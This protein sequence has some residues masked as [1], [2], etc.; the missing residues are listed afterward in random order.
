M[1]KDIN[2]ITSDEHMS[3]FND[4]Y[5]LSIYN[6]SSFEY[7]VI[8]TNKLLH[9]MLAYDKREQFNFYLIEQLFDTI[10][11]IKNNL[12]KISQDISKNKLISLLVKSFEKF[13]KLLIS[14]F[15]IYNLDTY[16]KSDL[17]S[18]QIHQNKIIFYLLD[19][20]NA[21]SDLIIN[22][23]FDNNKFD[24]YNDINQIIFKR[25]IKNN[26]K[27]RIT[28]LNMIIKK[29][30]YISD[31]IMMSLKYLK[32][33]KVIDEIF[34]N[35]ISTNT[36]I[37][38]RYI[39]QMLDTNKYFTSK[40]TNF[41]INEYST[42]INNFSLDSKEFTNILHQLIINQTKPSVILK[43][44]DKLDHTNNNKFILKL[45]QSKYILFNQMYQKNNIIR[46]IN[47]F[48]H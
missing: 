18:N 35:C 12:I 24:L 21:E 22:Y 30:P 43:L 40:Y 27:I 46:L 8:Y 32:N 44:L 6:I 19:I 41:F 45:T 7:W 5:I 34:N 28:K 20:K 23:L 33:K 17:H 47:E 26:D 15:D 29:F 37:S 13:V 39:N 9:I 1:L 2:N 11:N 25:I 48:N 3:I 38:Y 10:E 4:L 14:K 31:T 42:Y 36:N 16:L